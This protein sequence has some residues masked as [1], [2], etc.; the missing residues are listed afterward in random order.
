MVFAFS[1]LT[2]R[3]VCSGS[4]SRKSQFPRTRR[5]TRSTPRIIAI[6]EIPF[7]LRPIEL[8]ARTPFVFGSFDVVHR[9]VRYH[10][11]PQQ[12]DQLNATHGLGLGHNRAKAKAHPNVIPALVKRFKE[13][14]AT[15]SPTGPNSLRPII[16]GRAPSS[17]FRSQPK[18]GISCWMSTVR[19]RK[20]MRCFS[21]CMRINHKN[22]KIAP[23]PTAASDDIRRMADG[24]DFVGWPGPGVCGGSDQPR[25][26]RRGIPHESAPQ[27]Y[28]RHAGFDNP[29]GEI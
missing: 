25:R 11:D 2:A 9:I 24:V 3:P 5:N 1:L 28:L 21:P 8:H 13:K 20:L 22:I 12:I 10:T 14:E 6:G 27:K 26:M 4:Q 16:P 29:E 23:R 18:A 19:R 17:I 15:N 7:D